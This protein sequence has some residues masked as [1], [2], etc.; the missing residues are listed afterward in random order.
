MLKKWIKEYIEVNKK[1][2]LIII[3]LL[4]LGVIIGVGI[5]IFVSSS[6]KAL[7]ITSVKEVFE[8]SKESTYVKTNIVAN[9]VKADILLI[10]ILGIASITL[11]GKWVMYMI[12][13]LKGISLSIYTILLFN[14]FGFLWGSLV[15]ILLVLLV[16]ILYIPALIYLIVNFLE[17]HFNIFKTR[18]TNLN[19]IEIYRI[20]LAVFFSFVIMFSSIVIEQIAS[21][22]VLNIYTKI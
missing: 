15:F 6:T 3:G 20:L 1:E 5:Y 8:I 21:P 11:F 17:I 22:I 16:N 2:V 10:L 4:L 19:V 12:V 9:G 13:L 7:A 18:I 14:I